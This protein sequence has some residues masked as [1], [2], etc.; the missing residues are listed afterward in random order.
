MAGQIKWRMKRFCREYNWREIL[1][2][3]RKSKEKLIGHW[4]RLRCL[5][6]D[7]LRGMVEYKVERGRKSYHLSMTK[8]CRLCWHTTRT[9]FTEN[10]QE[11]CKCAYYAGISKRR[12][13]R[14]YCTYTA[15]YRAMTPRFV[16][17]SSPEGKIICSDSIWL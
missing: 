17:T 8:N 15:W 16:W 5:L 1:E 2:T 9:D 13:P 3:I 12:D 4:L 14:P 11:M 7:L 10:R 6:V